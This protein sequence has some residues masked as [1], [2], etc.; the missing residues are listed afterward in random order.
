VTFVKEIKNQR[1]QLQ[2]SCCP[3]SSL[4]PSLHILKSSL[5][6]AVSGRAGRYYKP[7]GYVACDTPVTNDIIL[8]ENDEMEEYAISG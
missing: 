5:V 7:S 3:Y 8:S 1:I 2:I 6:D 4:V